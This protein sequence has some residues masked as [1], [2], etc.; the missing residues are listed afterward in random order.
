M[1]SC[2]TISKGEKKGLHNIFHVGCAACSGD[3]TNSCGKAFTGAILPIMAEHKDGV[4]IEILKYVTLDV[5][6]NLV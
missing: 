3:S 5:C 2:I 6:N 1:N 4:N